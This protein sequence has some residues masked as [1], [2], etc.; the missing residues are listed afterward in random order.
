MGSFAFV[1]CLQGIVFVSVAMLFLRTKNLRM[2]GR[3]GRLIIKRETGGWLE[4]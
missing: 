2:L 3:I 4:K 1:A